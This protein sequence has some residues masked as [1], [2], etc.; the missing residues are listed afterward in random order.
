MEIQN[1]NI[2]NFLEVG[3]NTC[4]E[5]IT[6]SANCAIEINTHPFLR[7]FENAHIYFYSSCSCCCC[8]FCLT[9]SIYMYTSYIAIVVF[10]GK[11][12][13][14]DKVV[15]LQFVHTEYT[16]CKHFTCRYPNTSVCHLLNFSSTP[17]Q[18]E[19]N[20]TIFFHLCLKNLVPSSFL[21]EPSTSAQ[22][23]TCC[24]CNYMVKKFAKEDWRSHEG[25][26]REQVHNNISGKSS[27]LNYDL[28]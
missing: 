28:F 24:W 1:K 16:V 22:F 20:S 27:L 2:V 7:V 9:Y 17:S 10:Y 14:N 23:S 5:G 8:W 18:S 4:G 12:T 19:R 11:P 15:F 6:F 21:G 3:L 25:F 26:Q 13:A